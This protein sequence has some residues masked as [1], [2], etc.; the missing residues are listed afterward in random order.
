M[1]KG[2]FEWVRGRHG[3]WEKAL[4][5]SGFFAHSLDLLI[6]KSE[7]AVL[8]GPPIKPPLE[9]FAPD[10]KLRLPPKRSSGF[11]PVGSSVSFGHESR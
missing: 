6:L 1:V 8:S 3:E 9:R 7:L 2:K 10:P 11:A 4:E 5:S